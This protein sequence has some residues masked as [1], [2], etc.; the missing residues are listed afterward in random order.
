MHGAACYQQADHH[1]HHLPAADL[2]RLPLPAM[3]ADK[4]CSQ[5]LVYDYYVDEASGTMVPWADKVPKFAYMPGSF[6]TLF[7]PTVESTRL[8][9]FLDSL[10]ARKHYVMFVGNTGAFCIWLP[11]LLAACHT[12][13][14]VCSW[15]L[16]T[17]L[18]HDN[19]TTQVMSSDKSCVLRLL[20]GQ[21]RAR[22]RSCATSC[23]P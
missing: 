20:A 8:T 15:P 19:R 22:R 17:L 2:A 11:C 18:K 5:G 14:A 21:A 9:Y 7:V 23:R 12:R 16:H 6:S 13:S 3:L 4:L 1:H 10:I